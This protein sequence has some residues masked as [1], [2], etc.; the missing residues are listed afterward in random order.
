MGVGN[1]ITATEFAAYLKCPT[2][3]HLVGGREPAPRTLFTET[4]AHISSMYKA[5]LVQHTSIGASAEELLHWDQLPREQDNKAISHHIDCD[6]VTY[7]LEL[8][9][10]RPKALTS[11]K[12]STSASYVPVLLSPWEKLSP[13]DS[14][15]VCFGALALS[16]ATGILPDAGLLIYGAGP[17]RRNVKI[18]DHL[19]QTRQ[20]IEAI[21]T[22]RRGRE[23]PPLILNRHC[24][25]CDFQQR[26]RDLAIERD[27]LSLLSAM[28]VKERT[29]YA[30]KGVVTI[31]QLSYGYRPRRRKRT[32]PDA[33]R[34][35]KTAKLA[36]PLL[37]TTTS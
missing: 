17:R 25:I 11:Q 35:A 5:A 8:P 7:D 18:G 9:P 26:C 19:T 4:E 24:A 22:L 33:E 10:H 30:A 1:R 20:T 12:S 36:K 3:G 34:S 13:S 31:T 21:R 15:L 37:K 2:K 14:L 27:E 16:Q 23:P 28:T 6:T 32:R 29:K